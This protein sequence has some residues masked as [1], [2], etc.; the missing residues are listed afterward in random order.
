MGSGKTTVARFMHDSLKACLPKRTGKILYHAFADTLKELCDEIYDTGSGE[1]KAYV[2]PWAKEPNEWQSGIPK[3]TSERLTDACTGVVVNEKQAAALSA[4]V[5]RS[6]TRLCGATKRPTTGMLL[7][8]VGQGAR[9]AISPNFW[10]TQFVNNMQQI[11]ADAYIVHDLRYQNECDL[12]K[13]L[14][15]HFVL[16][17]RPEALQLKDG[18]SVT[19]E[20][21]NGIKKPPLWAG[22]ILNDSHLD[23]LRL[24]SESLIKNIVREHYGFPF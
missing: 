11:P 8:S 15:A 3:I 7:Q 17:T 2:P 22:V 16:I 23:E 6:L 5:L 18:R 1:D 10:V 14:G 13:T 9:E 19:H 4:Y 12:L 21:E 24:R 20:S